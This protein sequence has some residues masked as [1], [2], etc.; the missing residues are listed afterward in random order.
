VQN[1]TMSG[2]KLNNNLKVIEPLY[3]ER[4]K[5]IEFSK[6][7]LRSLGLTTDGLFV[8]LRLDPNQR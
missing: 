1:E 7:Y 8:E 6:K 2:S 3:K 5:L 4:V